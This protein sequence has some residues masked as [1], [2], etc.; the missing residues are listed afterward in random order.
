M[1]TEMN[2]QYSSVHKMA[3]LSTAMIPFSSEIKFNMFIRDM[4]EECKN[5]LNKE[6]G[7]V[8]YHEGSSR[9]NSQQML[10]DLNQRRREDHLMDYARSMLN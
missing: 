7:L 10:K 9:K 3:D 4:N 5:P 1:F 8:L 2:T 6:D